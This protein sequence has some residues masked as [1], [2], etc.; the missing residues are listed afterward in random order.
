[1]LPVTQREANNRI[2]ILELGLSLFMLKGEASSGQRDNNLGGGV[3]IKGEPSSYPG[4]P[5]VNS[6]FTFAW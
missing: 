3:D 4:N 6:W 5:S 1:M 2:Y